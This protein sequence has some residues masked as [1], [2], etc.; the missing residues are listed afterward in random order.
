MMPEYFEDHHD[1]S[2][3]YAV[4]FEIIQKLDALF[5]EGILGIWLSYTGQ[6]LYFVHRCFSV[7]RGRFNH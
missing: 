5:P 3:I 4:N 6:Q 2:T 7:V 1:V